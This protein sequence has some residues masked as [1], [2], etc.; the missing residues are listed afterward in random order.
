MKNTCLMGAVVSALCLIGCSS[1][2]VALA[3]VGPNPAGSTVR[4]S[5][6]QLEVYSALKE[7]RDGNEYDPNPAWYQHT[8]YI[9]RD[10]DGKRIRH[11]GNSVGHYARRPRRI[12]LPPGKYLVKAEGKDGLSVT[13][14]VLIRP[15][16]TTRVHLDAAWHPAA[17][18]PNSELVTAPTG[19]PVGW[20]V[21]L[22]KNGS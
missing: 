9:V 21:D 3:P 17:A 5:T 20:R 22:G 7:C 19:Y 14:P 4:A 8:D 13:I 10:L 16:R 2:P 6:G 11:V 18:V 12:E 1:A 15:G